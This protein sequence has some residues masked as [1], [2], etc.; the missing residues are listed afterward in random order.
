[1]MGNPMTSRALVIT[2]CLLA[3]GCQGSLPEPRAVAR[4]FAPEAGV[5][6]PYDDGKLHLAAGRY[7]LAI[8]R[9]GQA[10]ASDRGSLDALNGLAI[11]YTRLGRFDIARGYFERALGLDPFSA[12]TLNNYGRA[13]IEQGRLRDAGPFL[14]LAMQHASPAEL[15]SVA[16]NV[17]SVRQ[18][19]PPA[20]VT[21]LRAT[22]PKSTSE[23]RR[24]IR[25][26]A[27]RYRLATP[28]PA[29]PAAVGH[30]RAALNAA[31]RQPAAAVAAPLRSAL[32][33]MPARVAAGVAGRS[34]GSGLGLASSADLEARAGHLQQP[35]A[36]AQAAIS[37][38]AVLSGSWAGSRAAAPAPA[39]GEPT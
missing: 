19:R 29:A 30:G 15:T 17:E 9:F 3:G 1:M 22:P 38:A 23:G 4:G 2:V 6:A 31:V 12:S 25:L 34:G 28:E 35:V 7:G 24:L 21:A 16:A 8:K 33:A 11:A 37:G 13:L 10:L 5:L 18:T 14:R 39:S 20:L 26:A 27:G 32:I 36:R